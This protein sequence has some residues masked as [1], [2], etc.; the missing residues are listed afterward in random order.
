MM[1]VA[2]IALAAAAIGHIAH[3]IGIQIREEY[4][5]LALLPIMLLTLVWPLWRFLGLDLILKRCPICR[6]RFGQ[7]LIGFRDPNGVKYECPICHGHFIV[8]GKW[9]TGKHSR[10]IPD[11][12]GRIIII[13]ESGQIRGLRLRWPQ[14]LGRWKNEADSSPN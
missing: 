2:V 6:K 12:A 14:I 11:K 8:C 7:D 3:Y 13:G 10:F 1:V 5:F 4:A 9:Q